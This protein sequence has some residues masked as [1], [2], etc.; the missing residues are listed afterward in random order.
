PLLDGRI[1]RTGRRRRTA[2]TGLRRRTPIPL[3]VEGRCRL[4]PRRGFRGGCGRPLGGRRLLPLRLVGG[5]LRLSS[6]LFLS[7][8]EI[9]GANRGYRYLL[10]WP[11]L[12]HLRPDVLR[13]LV[14]DGL[15]RSG[16][17]RAHQG[18]PGAPGH[19]LQRSEDIHFSPPFFEIDNSSS[20]EVLRFGGYA[21]PGKERSTIYLS[22][23]H[24]I[25][26][27]TAVHPHTLVEYV[28][29]VNVRGTST[30]SSPHSWGTRCGDTGDTLSQTVHP[31]P[32]G[33]HCF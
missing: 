1:R 20:K 14:R 11:G 16:P 13:R 22:I 33:E 7:P 28:H 17:E 5:G 3:A 10:P 15:G 23:P 6:R 9:R 30:G 24:Y 29:P 25:P 12:N 2:R 19:R 18:R 26:V 31:H 8:L 32:C 4:G 21:P 27:E